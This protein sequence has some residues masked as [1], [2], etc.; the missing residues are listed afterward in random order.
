MFII[1]TI[2]YHFGGVIGIKPHYLIRYDLLTLQI[3]DNIRWKKEVYLEKIYYLYFVSLLLLSIT[4]HLNAIK[5]FRILFSSWKL[6]FA[7]FW[8]LIK[9]SLNL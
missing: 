3:Q 4:Y 8:L 6:D 9:F 7:Y 1:Y 2:L 5:K